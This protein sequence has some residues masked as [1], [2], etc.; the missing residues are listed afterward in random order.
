MRPLLHLVSFDVRRFRLLLAAW[1]LIQIADT[2]FQGVQPALSMDSR[3]LT[4]VDLLAAMLY[5]TRWFGLVVIIPLVVQAHPLVGSDAFWMTRPIS[6]RALFAS[7]AVLLGT[8][9][10][11]VPAL[12][13]LALMLASRVPLVDVAFVTLQSILFQA[14]WLFLIMALSATR[15]TLAGFAL[16]V[17]SLLVALVLLFNIVIAVVVRNMPEGPQLTVVAG[18]SVANPTAGVVVLMVVIAAA[19]AQLVVQ[20]RT[21]SITASVGVGLAGVAVAILIVLKWPSHEPQVPVPEWANRQ[22]ALRLVADSEKGEFKLLE[23]GARWSDSDGWQIGSV[24][25]RLS[26][27][28]G[29]WLGT[30]RLADGTVQFPDGTTLAT[31]GN[32]YSSSPVAFES[33]D[34]SPRRVAMRHV[35]GVSR[36]RELSYDRFTVEAMPAI[37]VKQADYK[38]YAGAIGTYRG[39]FLV[40]LDHFEIAATLPLEPGAE[41]QDRR[42][43]IVLDQVI[44]QAQSAS[45]RLR[46]FT[47]ATMFDADEL[48]PVS[49]YLRNR[50]T[51]EAVAG[52]AREGGGMSA[53][54]GMPLFVVGLHVSGGGRGTGFVVT[55]NLIR[56]PEA[57]SE[58]PIVGIN[59]DWLSH[60]ELVVVTTVPSGSVSRTL[61]ISNFAIAPAAATGN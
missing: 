23:N 29:G 60:A 15:R 33:V 30:V 2:I 32:G 39:H 40:D 36:V 18:R 28:E 4:S 17:G 19:I 48:P 45:I 5:L 9:M 21:R 20:Y 56:F 3:L 8:M 6:W 58:E 49:F 57:P 12:C 34:D 13:E 37:V 38:R 51:A 53:G 41:F 1:V 24:R 55:G 50:D 52:L 22:S 44:R 46:E 42:R 7:K 61:E 16:V 26:G 11:V 47:A 10:V 27:V 35:L 31:A 14:F 25:L 54:I 43:R 59:A